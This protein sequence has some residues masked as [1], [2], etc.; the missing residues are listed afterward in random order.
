MPLF[1]DSF[2][3]HIIEELNYRKSFNALQTALVPHVKVTS[4]VETEGSWEISGGNQT[5]Q[6]LRGFTL[7]ITDVN[8]INSLSSYFNN[9]GHSGTAVGL[10]YTGTGDSP[11]IVSIK[12]KDSNGAAIKN[13]PPPGVTNVS[14]ST[15]SK[16]GFIFK[17]VINL[18]FYGKDQYDFIYQTMLRPGNPIVIEYGHTRSP[19][20]NE[21]F[22]SCLLYTSDAADE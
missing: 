12:T 4:L 14:I 8:N 5:Y 16:G 13:L 21:R 11:E 2:D 3:T 9:S 6:R 15:Q 10:T 20:T 22:N 17:A 18:K 19:I 1:K 7:G